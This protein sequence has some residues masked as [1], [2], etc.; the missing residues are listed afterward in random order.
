LNS[1]QQKIEFLETHK[2]KSKLEYCEEKG[3][4]IP[5]THYLLG[6]IYNDDLHWREHRDYETPLFSKLENMTIKKMIKE[7]MEQQ[8]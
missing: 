6:L 8:P 2:T 1:E 7:I 3:I 4:K 5:E